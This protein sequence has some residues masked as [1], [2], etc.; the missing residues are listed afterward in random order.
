MLKSLAEILGLTLESTRAVNLDATADA[1]IS[2]L[3]EL[4]AT[5][6]EQHQFES[7]DMVRTKLEALGIALQDSKTGTTW[8]TMGNHEALL[9]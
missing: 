7:A 5:L 9:R 1:L 2:V 8:T 4:R 6:R 3:I